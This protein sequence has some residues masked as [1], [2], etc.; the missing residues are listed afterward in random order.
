MENK[1]KLE[2]SKFFIRPKYYQ[3]LIEEDLNLYRDLKKTKVK[4]KKGYTELEHITP[5]LSENKDG[6][7]YWNYYRIDKRDKFIHNLCERFKRFLDSKS[8]SDSCIKVKLQ[9]GE[10]LAFND[11]KTLH[12]RMAFQ[13]KRD[14]D[15]L[16][17]VY[18]ENK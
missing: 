17:P 4:I 10:C 13:A 3:D 9:A 14:R 16:I 7:I 8:K 1:Y 11:G 5:I 15:R 18:V 2:E 12:G 6:S